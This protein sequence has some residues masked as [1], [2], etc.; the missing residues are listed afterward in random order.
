MKIIV[1]GYFTKSRLSEMSQRDPFGNPV[2]NL[3]GASWKQMLNNP[4]HRAGQ[5]NVGAGLVTTSPDRILA[6][7]KP[8]REEVVLY[9]Y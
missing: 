8:L 5:Q 9:R 1:V 6:D 4:A 2:R 7:V 3:N